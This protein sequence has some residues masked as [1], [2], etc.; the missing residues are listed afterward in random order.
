MEPYK[1]Y[2]Q[3][4]GRV[5]LVWEQANVTGRIQDPVVRQ[6][7]ARLLTLAQSRAVDRRPRPRRPRSRAGPKA[8][9]APSASSPPATSPGSP[10]TCIP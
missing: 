9:K 8:P 3:R 5:D 7:I 2:P 1:W 10:A 6:E 4:A